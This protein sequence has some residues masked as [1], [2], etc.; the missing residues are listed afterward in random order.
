MPD[1]FTEVS[2]Q[3]WGSRIGGAFK[4]ILFGLLLFI[5]AF[6]LLFWNEGRAIKTQKSLEEGA[7]AVISVDAAVIDPKNEGKLVYTT[8]LATTS[9]EL[10][11]PLFNIKTQAIRLTRKVLIY[12]WYESS[13]SKTE[14]ELG[15]GTKTTTSYTYAKKWSSKLI[16]SS[17]FKHPENHQNPTGR[18]Y[19]DKNIYANNVMLG[20]FKLNSTQIGE[21]SKR[22]DIILNE[23][24]I[25]ENTTARIFAG[26]IYSGDPQSPAVGDFRIS[27]YA[28]K[29]QTISL[30]AAQSS[31]SFRPYQTSAGKAIQILTIG[32]VSA[33][34]IFSNELANNRLLT[35]GLRLLGFVLMTI[36]LSMIFKPLSVLADVIPMLGN[37]LGMGTL[38]I[39]AIIAF[40]FS[41]LTI[42]M[43][44]V[45]YRPLVAVILISAVLGLVFY[46]KKKVKKAPV[47][48]RKDQ[49]Q[50][51][52]NASVGAAPPPPPPP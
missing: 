4:G 27:F 44:W 51:I 40:I 13:E 31:N 17:S 20:E 32:T 1:S 33:Q 47:D 14:K 24:N 41:L 23:Q 29:P 36:G 30:I 26:E 28:I 15:G 50:K 45:F 10:Q 22:S 2:Q 21:I 5:V 12:Q 52:N 42:A 25:P 9:E 48:A 8:G 3:S 43:A 37:L 16:P 18:H 46:L 19:N 34:Q 49:T 39:S 38:L 11:D 6:P 7:A 35:W